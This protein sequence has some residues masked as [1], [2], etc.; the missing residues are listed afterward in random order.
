MLVNLISEIDYLVA[1][2][3]KLKRLEK[4]LVRKTFKQQFLAENSI[5]CVP[6]SN[7]LVDRHLGFCFSIG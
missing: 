3:E 6:L 4:Y 7:K 1:C 2:D 5:L